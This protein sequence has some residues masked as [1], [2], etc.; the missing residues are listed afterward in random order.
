MRAF[1]A[2][3]REEDYAR[4]ARFLASSGRR[5]GDTRQL[6]ERGCAVIR[7]W[8]LVELD[9]ISPLPRG[10]QSDAEPRLQDRVGRLPFAPSSGEDA[11]EL[12]RPIV[13]AKVGSG[14]EARW[15]VAPGTVARIDAAYEALSE[16]WTRGR[17]PAPLLAS[18][19]LGLARWQWLGFVV[20]PLLAWLL[21]VLMAAVLLAVARLIAR[22]TATTW[23]DAVM[24]RLLGPLRLFLAAA[25]AFPLVGLLELDAQPTEWLIRFLRGLGAVALFWGLVRAI[26]ISEEQLIRRAGRAGRTSARTI[27]PLVGHALRLGVGLL[28]VLTAV[29]QLGYPVA[30]VL[31]GLGIGGIAIALAAQKTVENV[32]GSVS[33][34]ADRVLRVGDWVD[35]EGVAGAVESIGLRS[36]RLRTVDRTLV[37]IPNGRLAELRVESFGA[38]DRI[39]LA[40]TLRLAQ[41]TPTPVLRRVTADVE[42]LLREH[43]RVWPEAMTVRLA[44]LGVSSL[45]ITVNAWLA[46]PDF[47][48]F[49]GLRQELLLGILECVERAG[50]RLT[51]P[52]QVVRVDAAR[53]GG[54]LP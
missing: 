27:I 15:V 10:D 52:V 37:T 23:D 11:A 36:T 35:V 34:A 29:A 17:L 50:A 32:F 14:D 19:P 7:R 25:F 24:G 45:D 16:S 28:A 18:G 44:A 46:T 43:P 40:T 1:L 31:A 2:A 49:E 54:V 41:D 3:C 22:R 21:A 4:A 39:R 13:L 42:R 6:A 33:L 8:V 47:A 30:T 48:E 53:D 26:T 12:E 38:R 20:V 5:A 51:P 9:S